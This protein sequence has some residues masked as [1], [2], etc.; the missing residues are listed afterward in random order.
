MDLFCLCQLSIDLLKK[1]NIKNIDKID[2]I[3]ILKQFQ[4]I[5]ILLILNGVYKLAA[6]MEDGENFTPKIKLS[7]NSEKITNPGN[8]KIYQLFVLLFLKSLVVHS[9]VL[10]MLKI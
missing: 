9:K 5:D 7:D 3:K 2:S 1:F 6:I 4:K 10:L 8:K